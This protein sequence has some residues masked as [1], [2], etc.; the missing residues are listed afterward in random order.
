MYYLLLHKSWTH[1]VVYIRRVMAKKRPREHFKMIGLFPPEGLSHV[2][3]EYH[4]SS[5]DTARDTFG[6]HPYV[7]GTNSFKFE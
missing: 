5:N 7:P 4:P 3:G 6:L 1:T 2:P